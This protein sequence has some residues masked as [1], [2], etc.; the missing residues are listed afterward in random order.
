L[1]HFVSRVFLAI[2]QTDNRRDMGRRIASAAFIGRTEEQRTLKA[3]LT[4]AAGGDPMVALIGGEAGIGKTR[5]VAELTAACAA[6]GTRVLV[7]GCVPV[8][9]GSLPYAPIVEVLRALI[10]ELGPEAVRGLIGPAWP[11][12]AR[13][14]PGLG[15]PRDDGPSDN[16]RSLLFELLLGLFG[17]LSEQTPLVLVI[18]DLHWADRSTRDLL[19]FLVRNLHRERILLM[20]TYRDDEPGEQRL[21]AFLAELDRGGPVERI[22]LS[23]FDRTQTE[24]QL[25][26]ILGATPDAG[27]VHEVFARSEG[28]PFFTEELL[29]VGRAGPG[30]LP[31]TLRDLLGGRVAALPDHAGQLLAVVAVAGRRLSHRLLAAVTGLDDRDLVEALRVAVGS[32]L[33]VTTLG[34][35]GYEVRHAL[36]REVV[37]ADL[38]PGERVRLH[39]RLAR[40]LTEQP[41]LADRSPTVATAE[42]AAHWDAAGEPARALGARVEAGRAAEEARAFPESHRHYQRALELWD[43]VTDPGQ[44]AGMDQVEL[45]TRAAEAAGSSGQADRARALLTEAIC[46]LDPAVPAVRAALLRMQ[47]AGY[48]WHSDDERGCLAALDQAIRIL[49]AEP[50]AERARVLGYSA[51]WLMLAG[52]TRDAVGHAEQALSAARMVGARAEEG[53]ALDILGSCTGEVGL[54]EEARRIAEEVGNA[55]GVVRADLNLGSTLADCGRL[56][57]ALDV[58]RRGMAAA[59]ELGLERAMGSVVAAALA[60]TLFQLGDWEESEQ[61]LT[62]ALERETIARS[63]HQLIMGLLTLG[64]GDFSAAREHLELSRRL[65]SAPF[66]TVWP[67]T[68]L[69]ELAVW[70]GRHDDARATVDEAVGVLEGLDPEQGGPPTEGAGTYALGLRV[71]ADCAELARAARSRAGVEQARQHAEPLMATLRAMTGPTTDGADGQGGGWTACY[72]SLGAAEWS[73]LQG[74]PEPRLFQQAAESWERLQLPYESAYARFRQAEALLAVR[75]PRAGIQPVLRAAYQTTLMLGARPLRREIELLAGRGRLRLQDQ[76]AAAVVPET[77][78]PAASFG[79][80]RREAEILVLV[81]AGRTNRQIGGELFITEKTASVHVSRILAKLGV[82]G[83]GEAAAVAHRLGLDR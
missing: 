57:D 3:A 29:T 30:A 47:L 54:L 64:R 67:L 39:A 33:L 45:L 13:L 71:E 42:L 9:E 43:E 5:M 65:N 46:Q 8:G 27:L 10:A 11:E 24:A 32:Q 28:N 69:T 25:A 14:S 20:V 4:R 41:M 36:L 17:R 59:R 68:G 60:V 18:E 79:L 70:E 35:D 50:S 15:Q 66:E 62:R 80:T 16:S 58:L 75:A 23:R 7:G 73:R 6:D 76:D 26:S 48:C 74:R 55:E 31:A 81:A 51:Q 53:H 77:P 52:R 2:K 1:D 22:A 72:A 40:T 83:R 21:G 37:D 82:A 38:L 78:A 63:R 56:R 61:V 12:L 44:E 34:E 19:A 49:P